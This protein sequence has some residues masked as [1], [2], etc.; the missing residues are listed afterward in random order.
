MFLFEIA[1]R[2]EKEVG[3]FKSE[4]ERKAIY[5]SVISDVWF[6]GSNLTELERE[7][8]TVFLKELVS[9]GGSFGDFDNK[10]NSFFCKNN[11]TGEEIE[12]YSLFEWSEWFKERGYSGRFTVR[13]PEWKYEEATLALE[14]FVGCREDGSYETGE[15]WAISY[16]PDNVVKEWSEFLSE[17]VLRANAA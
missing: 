7:I 2:I 12:F 14:W 15:K 1:E 13:R 6:F 4:A 8:A 16:L 17:L 3:K 9:A 5:Q 10:D 11:V